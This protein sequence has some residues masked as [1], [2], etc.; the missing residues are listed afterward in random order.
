MVQTSPSCT[1]VVPPLFVLG[2][3]VGSLSSRPSASGCGCAT[4]LRLVPWVC[5]L[6]FLVDSRIVAEGLV[7]TATSVMYIGYRA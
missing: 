2:K 7:F 1:E 5:V 6:V 4:S 3:H